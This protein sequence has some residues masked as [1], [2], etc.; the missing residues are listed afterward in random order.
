[1]GHIKTWALSLGSPRELIF[2]IALFTESSATGVCQNPDSL[3]D[4]GRSGV[5]R[6]QHTP[7]RIVPQRGQVS[8][9]SSKPSTSEHWGV[10]HEDEAGSNLANDPSK[11]RPK[12][13]ACPSDPCPL[14]GR[15]N[16]LAGEPSAYRVH[17]PGPRRSVEGFDI[18]P[19]WE[20]GKEPI[21]LSLEENG[22]RVFTQLD[23]ADWHMAE[24]DS[25]KDSAAGPG[26]QVQF[27]KWNIHGTPWVVQIDK[28]K[29]V[30]RTGCI[31]ARSQG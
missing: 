24:K 22:S 20:P 9:N 27:T 14:P 1:V 18:I 28:I 25:A 23:G 7:F 17:L 30:Q 4:V 6:A 31:S 11:L 12:A 29:Q 5:V 19:D 8:E 2:P 3:S 16:V 13:G 10:F 15:G 21:P 26:E